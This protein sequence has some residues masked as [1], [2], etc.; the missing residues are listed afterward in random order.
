VDQ[1]IASFRQIA[2]RSTGLVESPLTDSAVEGGT[3]LSRFVFAG[4]AGGGDPIR[5]GLFAG[6]HGDEPAGS[7]AL[8]KLAQLLE[9]RPDV[10]Q[11]YL[12]FFYP[13]CNPTGFEDGTRHSRSGKDLNRE[14][15]RQSLEPEVL[16]LEQEIRARSFHG[17][18]SLHADD[19]SD[20]LYGFVR[21]AVLTRG[22]LE[23]ALARAEA[24]LPR[25]Q[26][27]EIDGFPA[28]NGIISECYDGILTSPPELHPQPFE[29]IL[30]TP[31]AAPLNQQ[32]EV[33]VVAIETILSEYQKLLSFAANL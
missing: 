13:V 26:R 21:G 17:L 2:A 11:G 12:L 19:T 30:E 24:V 28:E 16:L 4:P 1:V 31:H 7:V 33:F 29:I 9:H 25:N 5:I 18:V 27:P 32:A 15:W 14:F 22:L 6:I 3:T 23:P 8:V 20:G 10:A